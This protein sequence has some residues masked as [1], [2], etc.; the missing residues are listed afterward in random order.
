M[1]R[2]FT[3]VFG[4][5]NVDDKDLWISSYERHN[6]RVKDTI[7]ARQ[8]L[9]LDTHLEKDT[10]W[11]KLCAFL[12]P[13]GWT[14][15]NLP[16]AFP[17]DLNE[18]KLHKDVS[19]YSSNHWTPIHFTP[20]TDFAY[21]SLLVDPSGKH[22]REHFRSFLVAVETLRQSGTVMDVVALVYGTIE[23]NEAK[24]LAS[25][26][27]KVASVDTVGQPLE[28]RFEPYGI[29][30]E[31]EVRA[32][33]SVL[34]LVDYKMVLFFDI[35]TMFNEDA[36]SLMINHELSHDIVA[37]H[38]TATPLGAGFMLIR[39]S[40]QAYI[41]IDDIASTGTFSPQM[42]WLQYGWIQDWI[43]GS[44]MNNKDWHFSDASTDEGLL[45]YYYYCL[46]TGRGFFAPAD[47]WEAIYV[48]L[49]GPSRRCIA[50]VCHFSRVQALRT[51]R[52]QSSTA[53]CR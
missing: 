47:Q 34:R 51:L 8:L 2:L 44:E 45:Y 46:N 23:D 7:P 1:Q 38:R 6:K 20:H 22:R 18:N 28:H 29:E 9:V 36:D 31:N 43:P 35:D 3:A 42:G 52:S 49:T 39:P 11:A 27:I 25:E 16:A 5:A 14:C 26:N 53:A 19:L 12:T 4:S 37:H 17:A 30:V 32:K 48:R 50:F 15:D 13:S 21:A 33:I 10:A 40:M 41:D 24:I